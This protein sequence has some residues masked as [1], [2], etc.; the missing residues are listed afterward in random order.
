MA[1]K[2]DISTTFRAVAGF[3]AFLL[4]IAAAWIYL[5]GAGANPAAAE[6]AAL[7]QSIPGQSARAL[8]GEQGAFNEFSSSLQRAASIRRDAFAV[9]SSSDKTST[10]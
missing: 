4:V 6:L 7:S 1:S 2:T 10:V 9:S 5:A 3:A 8:A